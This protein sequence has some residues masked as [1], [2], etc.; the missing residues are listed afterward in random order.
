VCNV[1]KEKACRTTELRVNLILSGHCLAALPMLF[2]IRALQENASSW[3]WS[4]EL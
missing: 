1:Q 2:I 4:S 3:P